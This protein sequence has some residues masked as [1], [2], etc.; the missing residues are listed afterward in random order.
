LKLRT[1]QPEDVPALL[2]I[3]R[4]GFETYRS[5][6]PEGWEPPHFEESDVVAIEDVATW[7]LAEEDAE[8][9]GHVLLIPASRSR[10]PVDDPR[11]GHLLMLFVRRRNWGTP[12][13]RS[14]HEAML[15]AAADRGF[16][17]LRLFTPAGQKRARR[18]YEREGWRAVGDFPAPHL[19]FDVVQY[20]RPCPTPS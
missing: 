3:S 17:E 16:T 4:E 5:F 13:A 2:D 9:V 1:A 18:F 10:E 8:P 7:I 19:G 11:L 14:L 15:D 6:A 20:R 12:V